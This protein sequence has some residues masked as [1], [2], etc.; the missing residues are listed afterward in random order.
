MPYFNGLIKRFGLAQRSSGVARPSQPNYF[1]LFSGSTQD[2]HDNGVHDIDAPTVA[3]QIEASG[4]TWKEY[5]EN[6]P[7]GVSRVRARP[8]VATATVPTGASTPRRSASTGSGTIPSAARTWSTS[9][10][11]SRVTSITR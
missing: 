11:S 1:A 5:A 4:R 6:R 7:P 10:R 8:V 9:P 2:V 3:D